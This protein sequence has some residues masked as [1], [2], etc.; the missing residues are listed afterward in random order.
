MSNATT[1]RRTTTIVGGGLFGVWY[2]PALGPVRSYALA[3]GGVYHYHATNQVQPP[4]GL[5]FIY[6]T[7]ERLET[8]SLGYGGG[9]GASLRLGPVTPFAEL[10]VLQLDGLHHSGVTPT[11]TPLTLGAR[12][13][14]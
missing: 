8:N 10:R 13:G 14:F 4:G 11:R 6:G 7:S 5:G 12:V 1:Y 9:L 3:G 2:F